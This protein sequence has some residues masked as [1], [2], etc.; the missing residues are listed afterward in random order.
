MILTRALTLV[1]VLDA[2]CAGGCEDAKTLSPQGTPNE[3]D[4]SLCEGGGNCLAGNVKCGSMTCFGGEQ[5]CSVNTT[6][7]GDGGAMAE[8]SYS[9]P[10]LPET[11]GSGSGCSCLGPLAPGCSCV[12]QGGTPVVTCCV[13]DAGSIEASTDAASDGAP[14]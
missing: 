2:F 13:A 3:G 6:G 7:C 8:K 11:C 10:T 9:C 14:E 5:Y 4:A 1:L 12:A